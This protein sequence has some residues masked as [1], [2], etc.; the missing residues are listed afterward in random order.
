MLQISND[1]FYQVSRDQS[2]D[3]WCYFGNIFAK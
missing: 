2:W 1:V 3:Q